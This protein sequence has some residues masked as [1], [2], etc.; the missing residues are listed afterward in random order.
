M[1][2]LTEAQAWQAIAAFLEQREVDLAYA[3]RQ[4][5]LCIC[6]QNLL[7]SGCITRTIWCRMC[8]RVRLFAPHEGMRARSL[9]WDRHYRASRHARITAA[10]LL[11]A[12]AR[13]RDPI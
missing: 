13:R 2:K 3:P 1:S 8:M 12:M 7:R 5:A 10:W 4:P 9:F 6:V 11:H